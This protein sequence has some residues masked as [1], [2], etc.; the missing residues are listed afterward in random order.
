M[1]RRCGHHSHS[2]KGNK[3]V[4]IECAK[5]QLRLKWNSMTSKRQL[6]PIC[7]G[8]AC[9]KKEH[10]L[11]QRHTRNCANKI[12]SA[13]IQ[14]VIIHCTRLFPPRSFVVHLTNEYINSTQ[15][16]M[17]LKLANGLLKLELKIKRKENHKERTN[18][19]Q[20]IALFIVTKS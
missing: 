2:Q 7:C 11:W 9:Q 15:N 16:F 6:L 12:I 13:F 3:G 17:L 4:S 8:I 14:I 19:N 20:F 18:R 10:R 1:F 5:F